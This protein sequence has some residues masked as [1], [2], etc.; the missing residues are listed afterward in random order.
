MIFLYYVTGDIPARHLAV[1]AGVKKS[2][3]RWICIQMVEIIIESG[4]LDEYFQ[5][6]TE[7]QG[8]YEAKLLTQRSGMP[9][10]FTGAVD[11][12]Q[13]DV[14]VKRRQQKLFFNRYK[15][16]AINCMAYYGGITGL[17]YALEASASGSRHDNAVFQGSK[18]YEQLKKWKSSL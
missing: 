16:K 8:R 11:G 1:A 18:L 10:I 9:E 2:K 4:F 7:E 3:C 14:W 12:T 17:F 5:L 13:I 6:P 15:R